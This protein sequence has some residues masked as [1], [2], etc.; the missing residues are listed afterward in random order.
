MLTPEDLMCRVQEHTALDQCP[1]NSTCPK[2][3][4]EFAHPRGLYRAEYRGI[5]WGYMGIMEKKMKTTIIR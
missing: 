4:A 1:L 2:H 3:L 5:Y